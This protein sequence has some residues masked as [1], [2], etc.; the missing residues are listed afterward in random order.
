MTTN[1][2]ILDFFSWK[3]KPCCGITV[4]I[5]DN[6]EHYLA[7]AYLVT[8]IRFKEIIILMVNILE[9]FSVLFLCLEFSPSFSQQI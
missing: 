3:W 4:K 5:N 8:D 9:L 7:Q 2:L 1:S 6:C